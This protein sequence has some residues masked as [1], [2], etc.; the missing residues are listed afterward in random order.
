MPGPEEQSKESLDLAA[1]FE[2]D[3][4]LKVEVAQDTKKALQESQ[5]NFC[6]ILRK[7]PVFVLALLQGKD[8]FLLSG[9]K[10]ESII[11]E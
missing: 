7:I 1:L 11:Q 9:G 4:G 2:R 8:I 5:S 10:R 3:R 6:F